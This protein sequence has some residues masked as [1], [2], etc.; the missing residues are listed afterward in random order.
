[1]PPN[2]YFCLLESFELAHIFTHMHGPTDSHYFYIKFPS[3]VGVLII[4][5]RIHR[6]RI[7]LSVA[8]QPASHQKCDA[9]LM[10]CWCC[11][12]VDANDLDGSDDGCGQGPVQ[13]TSVMMVLV[14]V[15]VEHDAKVR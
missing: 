11:G 6:F 8:S 4:W 13:A 3:S 9:M 14:V 12:N 10:W 7:N 2:Y 15:V 5:W 1:M